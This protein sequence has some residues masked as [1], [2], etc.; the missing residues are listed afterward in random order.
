MVKEVR[1]ILCDEVAF[2]RHLK[3]EKKVQS[4]LFSSSGQYVQ[5]GILTPLVSFGERKSYLT[6]AGLFQKQNITKGLTMSLC[7]VV[8]NTVIR[9]S[10]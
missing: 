6:C 1:P 7:D 9:V 2:K 4:G 10:L 8:V 3:N 5:P